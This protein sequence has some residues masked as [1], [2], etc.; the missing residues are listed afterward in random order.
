MATI[1]GAFDH[2]DNAEQAA[3]ELMRKGFRRDD[4]DMI[5]HASNIAPHRATPSG[6]GR[7]APSRAASLVAETKTFRLPGIGDVFAEGPTAGL[8]ARAA[9][10]DIGESLVGVLV[11]LDLHE[12]DAMPLAEAV[13]RG[14]TLLI[15]KCEDELATRVQ[16]LMRRHDAI[17]MS[18]RAEE[19]RAGGWERFDES[20]RPYT[21]KQMGSERGRRRLL[22]KK[23]GT[24]F[25]QQGA[26]GG[27]WSGTAP[28]TQDET[29]IREHAEAE[30][31]ESAHEGGA[32]PEFR[33]REPAS[34]L[35]DDFRGHFSATYA[36][37]GSPYE[38]Y[39]PAY[40]F[41]AMIAA[42]ERFHD[43]DWRRAEDD[44]HA[45]WEETHPNTWSDY[46]DALRFGWGA[47]RGRDYKGPERRKHQRSDHPHYIW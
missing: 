6:K 47:V 29:Q 3:D 44:I 25:P 1:I 20:A 39:E 35:D 5:S 19:W 30:W 28:H 34:P 42:H 40:R 18:A 23:P 21:V 33:P 26:G 31:I 27:V 7:A 10:G 16:E 46:R 37:M 13:R 32:S 2:I 14:G 22:E 43:R 8:L 17:D 45:L 24:A 4:V 36:G 15:V 38:E 12:A 9:R 41:G 11:N